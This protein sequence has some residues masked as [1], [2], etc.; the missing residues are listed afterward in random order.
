MKT[1]DIH[2]TVTINAPPAAV[3]KALMDSRQHSKFTGAPA[4]MSGKV[5]GSFTCYNGYI[6]GVNLALQR[7][8]LIVQAWQSE[9]W[10]HGTWSIVTFKLAKLAGGKT[11][12]T[13]SHVGVPA[14]DYKA[15]NKGW[16]TH[17]WQ[18]LKKF[19]EQN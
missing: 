19:L 8:K 18:P 2:H 5:G 6:E 3:F 17:Y 11:K 7:P 1:R 12:L 4:K 10:P 16:T 14:G 9:N 13:F 15:K